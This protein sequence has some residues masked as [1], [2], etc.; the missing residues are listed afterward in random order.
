MDTKKCSQCNNVKTVD[1]F[2]RRGAGRQNICKSCRS[3]NS[4]KPSTPRPAAQFNI[5][6]EVAA[7]VVALE[8]R[9]RKVAAQVA[10]TAEQAEEIFSH[11]TEYLLTHMRPD[12]GESRY[13]ATAH[14]AAKSQLG[15]ERTYSFYVGGEDEISTSDEDAFEFLATDQPMSLEDELIQREQVKDIQAVIATLSP[16]NQQIVRMLHAGKRP[17]EIARKLGVT[18]SAVSIRLDR[19]EEKFRTAGLVPA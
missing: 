14:L 3:I 10:D 4:R 9:L 1:M 12:D 5:A 11:V 8:A 6:E 18:R 16:E 17:A 2:H 19:I 7:Q 15:K 13:I